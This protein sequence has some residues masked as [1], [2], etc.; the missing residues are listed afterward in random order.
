MSIPCCVLFCDGKEEGM[1]LE[2]KAGVASTRDNERKVEEQSNWSGQ[3]R[4]K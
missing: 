1:V 3:K 2:K 4:K